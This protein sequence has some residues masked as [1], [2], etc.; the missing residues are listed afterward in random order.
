[1]SKKPTMGRPAVM[2]NPRPLTIMLDE[3]H[4]N[5]IKRNMDRKRLGTLAASVRDIIEH[6]RSSRSR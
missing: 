3:V 5:A 2:K 6:Y 4:R 1:M